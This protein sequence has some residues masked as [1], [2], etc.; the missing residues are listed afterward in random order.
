MFIGLESR[1]GLSRHG[2]K[3]VARVWWFFSHKAILTSSC[4][5][6]SPPVMGSPLL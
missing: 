2:P 5:T 4:S 1:V 6:R 3:V